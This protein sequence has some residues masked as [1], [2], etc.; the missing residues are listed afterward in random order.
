MVMK[1]SKSDIGCRNRE[2]GQC[3]ICSSCQTSKFIQLLWNCNNNFISNT[4]KNDVCPSKAFILTTAEPIRIY[5]SRN[6]PT[7]H[8]MDLGFF[9]MLFKC[10]DLPKPSLLRR[11][12]L[13]LVNSLN[14]NVASYFLCC[15]RSLRW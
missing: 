9:E 8:K 14:Y 6:L 10:V 5:F 2:I 3:K 1:W 4:T 13:M 15:K 12:L 11:S 7:S